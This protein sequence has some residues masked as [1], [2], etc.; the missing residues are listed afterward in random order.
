MSPSWCLPGWI[1]EHYFSS[2][3][4]YL[5]SAKNITTLYLFLFSSFNFSAR[6]FFC[7]FHW[8]HLE[9]MC[10]LV[11]CKCPEKRIFYTKRCESRIFQSWPPPPIPMAT[12]SGSANV[13]KSLS[14]WIFIV[15]SFD[16]NASMLLQITL[17]RQPLWE[18]NNNWIVTTAKWA[19]TWDF[20][21]CG[22]CDQQRLRPASANAQSDQSLYKSL[23]HS[24]TVKLLTGTHLEF[25]SL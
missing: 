6:S 20:Q 19:A 10:C 8:K 5:L 1:L 7:H 24:M 3:K 4:R 17:V 22:M 25:L 12:L 16:V 14:I 9:I 13:F 21:Q 11:Y 23:E 18:L 2:Y 15:S